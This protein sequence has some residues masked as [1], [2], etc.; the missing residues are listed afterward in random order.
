[1]RQ[2]YVIVTEDNKVTSIDVE[3]E[4]GKLTITAAENVLAKL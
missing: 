4:P 3:P 2:R 1:L